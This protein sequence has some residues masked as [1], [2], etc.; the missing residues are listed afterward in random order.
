METG[1]GSGPDRADTG[2]PANEPTPPEGK[3]PDVPI[4][5][6]GTHNPEHVFGSVE[7]EVKFAYASEEEG[8]TVQIG[9]QYPNGTH[10]TIRLSPDEAR[11]VGSMLIQHAEQLDDE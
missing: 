9:A 2:M 3:E 7:V 8:E 10:S 11:S 1:R 4:V 5:A 6:N